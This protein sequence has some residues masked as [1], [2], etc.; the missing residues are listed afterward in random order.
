[1]LQA[2]ERA[3][4][5]LALQTELLMQCGFAVEAAQCHSA[6]HPLVAVRDT[7]RGLSGPF[8]AQGTTLQ[9]AETS[10]QAGTPQRAAGQAAV[11]CSCHVQQGING[12][13]AAASSCR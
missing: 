13:D 12:V 9:S 10:Q 4:D 2:R 1:M 8:N 6:P 7:R 11:A 3:G 5:W